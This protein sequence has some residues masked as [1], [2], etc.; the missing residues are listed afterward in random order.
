M[1]TKKE[2]VKEAIAKNYGNLVFEFG[3]KKE[4][5]VEGELVET[6]QY[7]HLEVSLASFLISFAGVKED[8][9]V[10]IAME[11][12]RKYL[13]ERMIIIIENPADETCDNQ[14]THI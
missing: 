7:G 6:D 4:F 12:V 10:E 8:D 5:N 2:T 1:V 13:L 14:G 11:Q 3:E 9:T